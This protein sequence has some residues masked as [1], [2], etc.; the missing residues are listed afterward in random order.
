MLDLSKALPH[1]IIYWFHRKKSFQNI[2]SYSKMKRKIS[3]RKNIKLV[4]IES[5]PTTLKSF[6]IKL[7]EKNQ[8]WILERKNNRLGINN[9]NWL[10]YITYSQLQL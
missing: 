3:A 1:S 4:G 5:S 2:L 9:G 6:S 8:T 7:A 10:E